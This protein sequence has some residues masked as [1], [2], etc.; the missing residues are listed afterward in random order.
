[1]QIR[2]ITVQ[3]EGDDLEVEGKYWTN[4]SNQHGNI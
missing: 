1:M 3:F 4:N 2:G